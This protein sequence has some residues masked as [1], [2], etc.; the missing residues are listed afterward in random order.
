ML[1]LFYMLRTKQ[2]REDPHLQIINEFSEHYDPL[3]YVLLHPTGRLSWG[4]YQP[5][6]PRADEKKCYFPPPYVKTNTHKP[7]LQLA[8]KCRNEELSI[9]MNRKYLVKQL[10]E[11]KKW[12]HQVMLIIFFF[13]FYFKNLFLNHK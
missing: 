12:E 9:C 3:H 5:R 2:K 7:F 10:D 13:F 11:L 6:K 1:Y 4:L 8:E